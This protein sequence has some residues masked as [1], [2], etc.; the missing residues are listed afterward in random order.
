MPDVK[1]FSLLLPMEPIVEQS[2]STASDKRS[3]LSSAL[4]LNLYS[5]SLGLQFSTGHETIVLHEKD[6]EGTSNAKSAHAPRK[7]TDQETNSSHQ[8]QGC[9]FVLFCCFVFC[10]F[11]FVWNVSSKACALFEILGFCG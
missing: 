9:F 4:P 8:H 1:Q 2:K 3:K 7:S 11:V 6:G 10:F 5:G